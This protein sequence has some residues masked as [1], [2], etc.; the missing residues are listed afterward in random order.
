MNRFAYPASLEQDENGRIV[1]S[2]PDLIGAHTDGANRDEAIREGSDCLE[3]VVFFLIK[4]GSD[5]P[6][7]S[8]PGTDQRV[9]HL[10]AHMAAKAAL[11]LA[12]KEAAITKTELAKR[13]DVTENEARRLL[14]PKHP[15]KIQGIDAAL[16]V[17]G[18]TLV[19]DVLN[20]A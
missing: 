1:V 3:S 11:Y 7:P 6:M 2:F 13:L 19:I 18:K 9:F 4:D 5:I 15:S 8:E 17:L 16:S 20:A 14:D 10:S 12:W